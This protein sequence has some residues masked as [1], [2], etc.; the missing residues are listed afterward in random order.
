MGYTTEFTGRVTVV[1]PLGPDTVQR[2][3]GWAGTR[4]EDP[5]LPGHWCHWVAFD[6]GATIGWDGAEKFYA[7]E[8]WLAHVIEHL[9]PPGHVVDGTIEAEGEEPGDE[10]RIEV[11]DNVV[12]VVQRTVEPEYDEVDPADIEDWGERQWAAY[13]AKT[14]H[15]VVYV[16]RDGARH[17]VDGI[18]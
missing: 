14:R 3:A 11:R 12:H 5:G 7:A 17:E 9:L 10:W 16:I 4:H 2:L 1:P 15:D 13:A 18:G 8:L 6:D